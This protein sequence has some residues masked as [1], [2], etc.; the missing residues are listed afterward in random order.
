MIDI[1]ESKE[2]CVISILAEIVARFRVSTPKNG[3]Y[4]TVSGE[5]KVIRESVSALVIPF[6][7][8][9]VNLP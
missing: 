6:W 5:D 9:V 2:D 8:R 7:C 3:M 1:R 4:L